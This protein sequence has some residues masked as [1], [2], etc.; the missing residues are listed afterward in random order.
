MAGGEQCASTSELWS[1]WE[2][3]RQCVGF[4][5]FF[6]EFCVGAMFG[7]GELATVRLAVQHAVTT[8]MSRLCV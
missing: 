3:M 6:C 2:V 7:V 5:N 8:E 4:G 1:V